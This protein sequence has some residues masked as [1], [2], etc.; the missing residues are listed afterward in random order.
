MYLYFTW[1]DF[2]LGTFDFYS[3]RFYSNLYFLL[4]YI[5]T[6]CCITR[7]SHVAVF[8]LINSNIIGDTLSTGEF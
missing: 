2:V 7:Y 3:T 1:V 4:H 6:L 8:V 5:S